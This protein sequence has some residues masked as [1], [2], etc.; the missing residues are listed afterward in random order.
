M[1]NPKSYIGLLGALVLAGCLGVSLV[2]VARRAQ[3]SQASLFPT[4]IVEITLAPTLTPLPP[5]I[6]S[7]TPQYREETVGGSPPTEQIRLGDTVRIY[8]TQGKG[9]R[10]RAAP[11]LESEIRFLAFEGEVYRV[12]DGPREASGYIWWYLVAPYDEEIKGWAVENYLRVIE[13]GN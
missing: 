12:E 13:D 1:V 8:G 3:L 9:L 6:T 2:L 4:A 10:L 5:L 11:G 7:P